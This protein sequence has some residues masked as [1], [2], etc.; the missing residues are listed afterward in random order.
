M[1]IIVYASFQFSD[2]SNNCF[3]NGEL[4]LLY[5]VP[6]SWKNWDEDKRQTWLEKNYY[7]IDKAFN[8]AMCVVHTGGYYN[9]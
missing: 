3:K 4:S 9:D 1:R 8:D 6:K 7:K 2:D 5:D